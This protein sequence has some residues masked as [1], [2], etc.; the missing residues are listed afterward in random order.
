MTIPRLAATASPGEVA[1]ALRSRGCAV[2]ETLVPCPV[3]HRARAELEPW[4]IATPC[5]RDEFAGLRTRRT[6]GLLGRSATCRELVMHPLV[7]DAVRTVLGHAPRLPL[8]LTQVI[9]NGP[10]GP[11]HTISRP[12]WAVGFFPLPP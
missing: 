9:G 4:L 5:G 3:L 8:H 12:P 7:L 11:R 1:D 6:G 10:G 2:V